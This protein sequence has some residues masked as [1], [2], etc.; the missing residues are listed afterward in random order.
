M[1]SHLLAAGIAR[2]E[3]SGARAA[4][5]LAAALLIARAQ[6]YDMFALYAQICLAEVD[7]TPGADTAAADATGELR[8]QGV[9]EPEKWV[10][11]YVPG[12]SKRREST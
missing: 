7:S 1:Y 9:A 5:E 11:V 2:C 10:A 6:G 4:E 8:G 3:E 12:F